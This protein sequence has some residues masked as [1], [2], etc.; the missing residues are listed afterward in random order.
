[1][2]KPELIRPAWYGTS[3]NGTKTVNTERGTYKPE[4]IRPGMAPVKMEQRLYLIKIGTIMPESIEPGMAS[5]QMEQRRLRS[6]EERI[7]LN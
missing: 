5:L 2:N 6:R 1:M 7:S 3:P 4:L